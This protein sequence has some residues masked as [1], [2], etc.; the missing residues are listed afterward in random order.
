MSQ[1]ELSEEELTQL[2]TFLLSDACDEETFTV[3]EVHGYL[4]GLAVLPEHIDRGDWQTFIW[5]EPEFRDEEEQI[6][7]SDLLDDL[8]NSIETTLAKGKHLEP[9]VIETE[10]CGEILEAY[11]GWC[12][13]FMH[14]VEQHQEAWQ[15]I[16]K[17]GQNLLS[18][19]AKLA[20]LVEDEEMEMDDDEYNQW[21]ELLPG[22][23]SSLYQM[24][25]KQG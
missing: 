12:L 6:Y 8:Y 11:E 20:M 18:P 13:G 23:T 7:F 15:D 19:I 5:G 10:E 22:S 24:F 21:V 14:S 4:T 17:N 16:D 1:S 25:H 3:D 2:D 9:L